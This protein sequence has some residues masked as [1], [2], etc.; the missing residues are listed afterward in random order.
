MPP[1]P[2]G[3]PLRRRR[4]PA[5]QGKAGGSR[6]LWHHQC[7]AHKFCKEC[8]Q[9]LGLGVDVGHPPQM[10]T[11]GTKRKPWF[12]IPIAL[13]TGL[14]AGQVSERQP[15]YQSSAVVLLEAW[16]EA[17]PFACPTLL[18]SR[19]D[20]CV[21]PAILNSRSLAEA[22]V[23]SLPKE[24][25][26][27]IAET[28]YDVDYWQRLTNAYLRWRGIDTSRSSPRHRAI[29]ELQ[30]ARMTF[31]RFPDK[32]GIVMMSAYASRPRESVDIVN[33]YI[34]VLVTLQTR[35]QSELKVAKVL[36]P[37]SYPV[38]VKSQTWLYGLAVAF[39]VAVGVGTGAGAIVRRFHRKGQNLALVI[40]LR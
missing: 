2:A 39:A 31:T 20:D 18:S 40:R 19:R 24:S 26:D 3:E 22:V 9:R 8:G 17:Q 14:A 5:L 11:S 25:L 16:P 21:V 12:V 7:P 35:E 23:D 10:I 13:V 37:A 33:T 28:A 6:D 38:P 29:A 1:V 27:E 34:K 32:T 15:R 30:R 36:D 4:L